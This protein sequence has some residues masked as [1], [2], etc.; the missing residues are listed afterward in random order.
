MSSTSLI[1]RSVLGYELMMRALYGRH[2][3]DRLSAVA[4]EVPEGASVLELCCG[5]GTLY[6]RHLCARAGG[7]VGLDA[8]ERFVSVLRRRGVDAR[9]V[10]LTCVAEPLPRRDVAL[11]QASLYHF[12]PS[13]EII[14]EKMLDAAQD[15]VIVAEPIR[16][17]ATSGSCVVRLIGR[18]ASNP[19]VGSHADRFSEAT[20]DDLMDRYRS[21]TIKTFLVPGGREKVYVLAP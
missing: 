18:R 17:L 1:Y 6:Q 15:R 8:N 11:I 20:L 7:Y 2:Y 21:Q 3:G 10:D 4:A 16:N 19:G 9:L 13:A 5:P 12:M 14:I